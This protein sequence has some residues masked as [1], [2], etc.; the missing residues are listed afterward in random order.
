MKKRSKSLFRKVLLILF[1][2]TLL[3]GAIFISSL[4]L[5]GSFDQIKENSI[6][7]YEERIKYRKDILNQLLAV[8]I[9][10]EK[11]YEQIFAHC[12]ALYEAS[13][14]QINSKP[15]LSE[16][17]LNDLASFLHYRSFTGAYLIL[18]RDIFQTDDYPTLYLRDASPDAAYSD[19]SDISGRFGDAN[20]LKQYNLTLEST[21]KPSIQLEEGDPAFDFYY[22]TI[23]T[24]KQH[25]ELSSL[26]LGYWGDPVSLN[27][28]LLSVITYSIPLIGKDHTV[29]G[30]IGVDVSTDFLKT[31]LP[32]QELN[33][34][35]RN[36]YVLAKKSESG[37]QTQLSSGPAYGYLFKM[38]TLF[39]FTDQIEDETY[40][41][42]C[43]KLNDDVLGHA[44]AL[45]LYA[46]SSPYVDEELWYLVGIANEGELLRSSKVLIRSSQ[47]AIIVAS[48]VAIGAAILI[49][50]KFTNP[51]ISLV[52]QL[53]Q[54]NPKQR[55]HLPRVNIDE[56]DELSNSIEI[57]SQGLLG[58]ESRLSQIIY[59][60]DIPIGA[61]EIF[62]NDTVYCT[63]KVGELLEFDDHYHK[64]TIFS[65]TSF[66]QQIQQLKIHAQLH[67]EYEL[68]IE[69][70][71][72]HVYVCSLY[73][74][75]KIRK[76][77]RF[78]LSNQNHNQILIVMDVTKEFEEK[79]HLTYE[80]NHDSLTGLLNRRAFCEEVTSIMN[81]ADI[82][83]C[84][85]VLWD[86]D[87]L[88]F[89]NDTYGHDGGDLLIKSMAEIM[90]SI[91]SAHALP[92]RMAGDE[93]L[94]FYHHYASKDLLLQ[95]VK[96]LHKTIMSTQVTFLNHDI[97]N[98][99]VS[100]GIAFYPEDAKNYDDLI[101]FADFAMYDAKNFQKGSVQCYN[102]E[103]YQHSRML[104]NGH[105]ELNSILDGNQVRYAFQP[106]VSAKDG[107]I[108]GY[109]ALMRP[110]GDILTS[111]QDI[112]LMARAQSQLY[113]VEYLTWTQSIKQFLEAKPACCDVKLFINSIPSIPML[114]DLIKE[115]ERAYAHQLPNLVVE[116]I[117]TDEIEQQYLQ[118]KQDFMIR[119]NGKMAIDDFGSG[120]NSDTTLLNT[121]ADYIK[122]DIEL[123]HQI[124]Q[125]VN[126]QLMVKNI[127]AFA[128]QK[129][130]DV[131]AEGVETKEEMKTLI[132][133]DVDYMQGYYLG[134]PDFEVKNIMEHIKQEIQEYRTA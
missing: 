72:L 122:I 127:I 111:P 89:I 134:K 62:D 7:L 113:R 76:W 24:A 50:Y 112:M 126:R 125:D 4:F 75:N 99:K 80:R 29:Y 41:V 73:S 15:V 129:G 106:I 131:I 66:E 25:P 43:D 101:H 27:D 88:K 97:T 3:E 79:E 110:Q 28:D 60:L 120:Y 52:Q 67:E 38:N 32:Y 119:W 36:T 48:L 2:A 22:K 83:V 70:K 35:E 102:E 86:L 18:D 5:S 114:D 58:A 47:F 1:T 57:F 53:K 71:Q 49:S 91:P 63:E 94:I 115:L 21:W 104:M 12:D 133:L 16:E 17:L 85:M 20:L 46:R 19:N 61:I 81:A 116:L 130:T 37:F 40:L 105:K 74:K 77:M 95:T 87:N 51:I 117:E 54:A 90:K 65:K 26:D 96:E 108:H 34:E 98:I 33:N 23:Q 31:L 14:T 9:Y 64:D 118:V 13:K 6:S 45:N 68:E 82:N 132:E 93:F 10:D 103:M 123:I 92:A 100:V 121:E 55:I 84:A 56:I 124:N 11:N 42:S 128:H 30:V 109:E 8:D 69:D 39:S 59:S 44:S 78:T 107:S